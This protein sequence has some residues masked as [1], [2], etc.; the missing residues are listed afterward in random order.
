MKKTK[1]TIEKLLLNLELGSSVEAS[2]A[3]VGISSST[4]YNWRAAD[5]DFKH[6]TELSL[7]KSEA[8]WVYSLNQIAADPE[9]PHHVRASILKF[10]LSR[11]HP[12]HWSENRVI[13]LEQDDGLDHFRAMIEQTNEGDAKIIKVQHSKPQL[14]K[15]QHT[16][17]TQESFKLKPT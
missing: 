12:T 4:Y 11:R 9:T 10:L 3:T 1:A 6:K 16:L 7:R 14:D 2:C 8:V 15:G 17:E 13:E 5:P